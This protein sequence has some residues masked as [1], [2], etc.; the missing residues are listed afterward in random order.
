MLAR[1]PKARVKEHD[2]FEFFVKSDAGGRA[3]WSKNITERGAIFTNPGSCYRSHMTYNPALKRYLLTTIGEGKDTRFAGGFGIYDSP[4]PWGPW[5][6][7]YYT[8]AW[9]VGPGESCS[10]PSKW[11]SADGTSAWLVFSGDDS[12][13]VRKATFVLAK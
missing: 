7:V 13:S 9:D 12:F 11:F 10:L 6:T 1:V 5:T 2:A 4:E 8:N 3:T